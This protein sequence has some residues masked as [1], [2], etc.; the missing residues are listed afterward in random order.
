MMDVG[1][2]IKEIRRLSGMN[3]NQLANEIN[4]SASTLKKYENGEVAIT[5]EVLMDIA[6]VLEVNPCI[7]LGVEEINL[8][9]R[10]KDEYEIKTKDERLLRYDIDT[11]LKYLK[12]KHGKF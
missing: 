4:K 3:Q 12:M 6:E 9:D 11:Y 7:L 10:I 5:V 1:Q 8:I 2:K